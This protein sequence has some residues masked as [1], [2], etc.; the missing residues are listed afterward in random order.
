MRVRPLEMREWNPKMLAKLAD[1]G[2]VRLDAADSGDVPAVE[3]PQEGASAGGERK[4]APS[5][6]KTVAHHPDLMVP[7]LEFATVIAHQGLLSRRDSE[8]LALRVAWNCRSEFEWGHHVDYARDAGLSSEEI[9]RV[10]AGPRAS[11]WSVSQ[12]ALLEAADELHAGQHVSDE[13]WAKLA[14]EYTEPQLVELLFVVGQYTMLS[15]V[16]N[17]AGVELETGYEPLPPAAPPT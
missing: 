9:A 16:V 8:L 3:A 14:T 6:L 2:R 7:F 15:M 17:A 10:P 11:G 5:M 13:V 12:R 4:S 1:I